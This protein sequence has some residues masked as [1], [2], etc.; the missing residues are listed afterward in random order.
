MRKGARHILVLLVLTASL[1]A[2]PNLL[3]KNQG[4]TEWVVLLHGL[5]RSGRSLALLEADLAGQGYSVLNLDYPSLKYPIEYLA[6]EVLHPEVARLSASSP[7]KIH[8]V[9]HSMG[10]IVVRYYLK[11]HDLPGLGRVVMLTPPNQGSEL[12]DLLKRSVLFKK[13]MAPAGLELGT[14]MDSV[15]RKLG[16]ADF[17]LGVIAGSRSYNPINSLIL[18]GPDDGTVTVESTRMPGLA[19]FIVLPCSHN[20]IVRSK[21]AIG[22]VIHFLRH[23]AFQRTAG[24]G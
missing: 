12:A 2:V 24:S 18:E 11:H 14:D 21:T 23:G 19:D 5:G 16:G 7:A 15:P 20:S 22:Q 4:G 1:S 9:T 8:F 6:E 3:D 13:F 17:D 10:G